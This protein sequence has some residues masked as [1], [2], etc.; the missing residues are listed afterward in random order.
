MHNANEKN[1]RTRPSVEG[2]AAFYA[3]LPLGYFCLS[4]TGTIE[5][6]NAAAATLLDVPLPTLAGTPFDHYVAATSIDDLQ[7]HIRTLASTGLPQSTDLKIIKKD[8]AESFIRLNSRVVGDGG[9]ET[10]VYD[11][12]DYHDERRLLQECSGRLRLI[13]DNSPDMLFQQDRELRYIWAPASSIPDIPP[14][15]GKTDHELFTPEEAEHLVAL[16]QRVMETGRG[17]KTE[18]ALTLHAVKRT[19]DVVYE[20][21]RNAKGSIEGIMG[22]VRDITARKRAE[23][24]LRYRM[25]FDKLIAG[26][27]TDFINCPLGRFDD[28]MNNALRQIGGFVHADRGYIFQFSEDRRRMSNTFEWCNNGIGNERGRMQDL[29]AER[30]PWLLTKIRQGEIV[31]V[32]RSANLPP[33]ADAEKEVFR[34]QGIRSLIDIPLFSRGAAI[35]FVGFCTVTVETEWSEAVIDMLANVAGV[36]V[37]ALERKKSETAIRESEEKYRSVFDNAVVGIF[38]STLE[39]KLL[40]VNGAFARMYGYGSPGEIVRAVTDISAQLYVHPERRTDL[41]TLMR[42]SQGKV[43]DFENEY[44][45]RDGGI[46]IGRLRAWIACDKNGDENHIEGFVED[47]T[48]TKQA[49]EALQ[50]SEQKFRSIFDNAVVGIFRSIFE[51]KFLSINPA[52]AHMFGYSSS[53]EVLRVVSDISKQIYSHIKDRQRFIRIMKESKGKITDFDAWFRR[54]D[55]SSFLGSMHAWLVYNPDGSTSHMEGFIEDVTERRA[56]ERAIRESESKYR[57]IFENT[58]TATVIVEEDKTLSLVNTEFERLSGFSRGEIEGKKTW[59]EFVAPDERQ[60][61]DDYHRLRRVQQR[62]APVKYELHFV[63]RAGNSK[64]IIVSADIIPG[65]NKSVLS[66]LDITQRKQA[67]EQLEKARELT[68]ARARESEEGRRILEALMEH[69]PEGIA[70]ADAPDVAVRM[71]SRFGEQMSGGAEEVKT[72]ITGKKDM[73]YHGD[74]ITPATREEQPLVRATSYG[75]VITNE[76]WILQRS[77]GRR[78]MILVNAGPIRDKNGRITGGIMAWS[79]ITERRQAQEKLRISYDRLQRS[80]DGIISAIVKIVETRDPYTAGHEQRVSQ[81]AYAIA[82][83]MGLSQEKANGIRMAAVIHDIG[84]IYVPAEILS[85]PGTLSEMEFAIIKIHPQASY[86]ILKVIEFPWPIAQ[87]ALQHQERLNG[88]GYPLGLK[89]DDILLEARILSVADVVEAMTFYRPYRSAIGIGKAL[90]EIENN[91]G[92]LYDPDVVDACLRLFREKD[93]RF[94]REAA[95]VE[96]GA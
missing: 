66:L 3:A 72:A 95:A 51:G 12:T 11:V 87:I 75:E 24:D 92:V 8:R 15:E 89:G 23:Q 71:I 18:V 26:L 7:A 83:D 68:E 32:A 67:E 49:I 62:L 9:F 50:E 81:L 5:A 57:A 45:R 1:M 63:D 22:Y 46:F 70:I 90:E 93:F 21:W 58:G 79:D 96:S 29:P 77:D 38:R 39:G 65:T 27:S 64:D 4:P 35:G 33:A 85:K 41:V 82:L 84:K 91:K 88:S 19:F 74:G 34:T 53:D 44:R 25:E 69:I 40:S 54:K 6:A 55:G 86:D 43:L 47:I 60:R 78:L 30:F 56:A 59:K 42:K 20:P 10:V 13:T 2:N 61:M 80:I 36:F 94:D 17:V 31:Y 52:F 28:A 73:L 37:N 16:K 76:E 48:E 14:I